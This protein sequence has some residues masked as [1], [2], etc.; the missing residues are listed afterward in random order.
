MLHTWAVNVSHQQHSHTKFKVCN[1]CFTIDEDD[2]E[3]K[4]PQKMLRLEKMLLAN[5]WTVILKI[6]A[7]TKIYKK[8]DLQVFSQKNQLY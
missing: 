2:E 8:N 6:K 4:I 7:K 5:K 3:I 1:H